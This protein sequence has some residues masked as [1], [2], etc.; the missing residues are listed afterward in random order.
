MCLDR[1]AEVFATAG[2]AVLVYD[3]RGLDDSEPAPG[4]PR[5]EIDPWVQVGDY[6][7]AITHAQ[8]RSEVDPGRIGVW[9][10]VSRAHTPT[11]S[12][13]WTGG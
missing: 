6:R 1:F 7:H 9:E 5:H 11:S 8:N 2:P 3:I 4:Q 10:P 13:R 12:R